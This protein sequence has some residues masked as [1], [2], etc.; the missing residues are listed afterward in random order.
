MSGLG[1][2]VVDNLERMARLVMDSVV[3][4]C[5]GA[6]Y[7][8]RITTRALLHA[9]LTKR[10]GHGISSSDLSLLLR[11]MERDTKQCRCVNETIKFSQASQI[12]D[13]DIAISQLKS[14]MVQ[15][16]NQIEALA[17][18]ITDVDRALSVSLTKKERALGLLRTKKMLD[19]TVLQ[20]QEMQL[21]VSTILMKLDDAVAN[22]G[23]VEAMRAGGQALEQI[24]SSIGGVDRVED[25]LDQV[26]TQIEVGDD[27]GRVIAEQLPSDGQGEQDDE[28]VE[29]EYLELV[30]HQEKEQKQPQSSSS[31]EKVAN[32]ISRISLDEQNINDKAEPES[33]AESKAEL[34]AE[35]KAERQAVLA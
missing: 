5:G 33:R 6:G 31:V 24:L 17:V 27:I 35:S 18:R 32:D 4:D 20:R 14:T 30:K 11:F 34:K 10:L 1:Y 12:T 21:S 15:L 9:D 22:V 16:T 29:A 25:V 26:R 28:Q 19:T 8:A 3:A 23:V 2:V 13:S 7:S